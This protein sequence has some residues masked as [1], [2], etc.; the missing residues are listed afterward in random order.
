LAVF[1]GLVVRELTYEMVRA[2]KQSTVG[3]F[4]LALAYLGGE[5]LSSVESPWENSTLGRL[6]L[7]LWP[8]VLDTAL[9]AHP[10][11]FALT[12]QNLAEIPDDHPRP[13]YGRRYRL[14]TD[15]DYCLR[16]VRLACDSPYVLEGQ[17]L[18]TDAAP[19]V[20]VFVRRADD[21][22]QFPPAFRQALAAS[23]AAVLATAKQNDPRLRADCLQRS[24]AFLLEAV[25]SDENSQRPA[26][27]P[28][29]WEL[30]RMGR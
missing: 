14:P 25:A 17:D 10:W 26:Y 1:R 16:P 2:M 11:S 18:L 12:R 6:C 22:N 27:E 3:L 28:T 9:A 8:Q 21:P 13:G 29:P 20:L 24:Q 15:P 19:A 5:Q 30:A 4:N 23:L 7:N